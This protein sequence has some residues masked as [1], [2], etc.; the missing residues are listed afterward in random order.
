MRISGKVVHQTPVEF[1]PHGAV[2]A[3]RVPA[4][5]DLVLFLK[6][7]PV[8]LEDTAILRKNGTRMLL[9][10]DGC[11]SH[12]NLSVI[13]MLKQENVLAYALPSHKTHITQPLDRAIFSPLKAF[14]KKEVRGRTIA[15]D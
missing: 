7:L 11:K 4:G 6:W 10:Y 3:Q 14:F 15:T 1:L 2:V 5:V 13:N 8:F 12:V 9:I